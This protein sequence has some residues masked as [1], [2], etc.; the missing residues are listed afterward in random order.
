M[1]FAPKS[2][3]YEIHQSGGFGL[4]FSEQMYPWGH[5]GL[6][7]EVRQHL[8]LKV[9]SPK[10][11]KDGDMQRLLKWHLKRVGRS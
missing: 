9:S 2:Y 4:L 5:S 1:R 8:G 3:M 10:D 11:V 6:L 7:T